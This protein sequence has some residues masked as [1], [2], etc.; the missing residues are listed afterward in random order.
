[1][2]NSIRNIVIVY[3]ILFAA[4]VEILLLGNEFLFLN[5][6]LPLHESIPILPLGILL[7]G[8]MIFLQILAIKK[9]NRLGNQNIL[10]LTLYGTLLVFIGELI[11]QLIRILRFGTGDLLLD[12]RSFL[13]H[14]FVMSVFGLVIAFLTSFQIKTKK[15]ALLITMIIGLIIVFNIFKHLLNYDNNSIFIAFL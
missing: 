10:T 9:I 6:H 8:I 7:M 11:L 13:G 3:A 14:V 4:G 15:T 5:L 1:M 2:L 12:V